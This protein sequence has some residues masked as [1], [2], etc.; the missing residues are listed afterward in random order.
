M[1][2]KKEIDK[3]YRE[4][5]KKLLSQVQPKKLDLG[6][7]LLIKQAKKEALSSGISFEEACRRIYEK[8]EN[9][10]ENQLE[11]AKSCNIKSD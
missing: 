7:E 4:K 8:V 11:H 2:T 3:G 6:V 9:R 10:V 1:K 5:F